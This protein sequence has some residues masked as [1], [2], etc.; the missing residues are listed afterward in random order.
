MINAVL[1]II[2]IVMFV[3]FFTGGVCLLFGN[4]SIKSKNVKHARTIIGTISILSSS[5]IIIGRLKDSGNS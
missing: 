5:L 2:Q 1:K 3:L 4:I